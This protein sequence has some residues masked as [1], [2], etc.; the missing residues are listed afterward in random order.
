MV[1]LLNF[2]ETMP[3]WQL[4]AWMLAC[5]FSCWL[6]ESLI[7]LFRLDYHKMKHDAFN[8]ALFVMN[9]VLVLPVA[10]A[11]GMATVWSESSQVGLLYHIDLPAWAEL[12]LAILFLDLIAQYTVHYL[13]HHVKWMWRLHIVHHADTHVDATSGT[14]HHPGDLAFRLVAASVA[15]VAFGIPA[16]FYIIYRMLTPFFG[17]FTHANI[18][19]PGKLD[20]LLS[21]ILVTPDMHKFHHHYQAP[22]TDSNFGNIFSFWD[23]LFGTLVYADTK[24][25]RYGLDIM[26][27][28]RDLDF[29]YQ[30][31]APIDPSIDTSRRPG[32]T[33]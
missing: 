19:L 10:I 20:R 33:G 31:K 6:L 16:I 3:H 9:G 1:E 17:Y 28:S 23:R 4:L 26:D 15:I 11:L 21:Y 30:L 5:L 24:D 8:I 18:R 22:W 7:P 29:F 2:F 14:R 27:D 32:M 25:I 13:L 12:L